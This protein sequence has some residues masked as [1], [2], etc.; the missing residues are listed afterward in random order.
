MICYQRD[1]HYHDEF[2][3]NYEKH[4]K[5][6][7][8]L[9]SQELQIIL[10]FNV[11]CFHDNN[12]STLKAIRRQIQPHVE[13][14]LFSSKCIFISIFQKNY[15]KI[16]KHLKETFFSKFSIPLFKTF[17][18]KNRTSKHQI[19]SQHLFSFQFTEIA[20]SFYCAKI[21]VRQQFNKFS[22]RLWVINIFC[23]TNCV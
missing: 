4:A 6:Q 16:Q 2:S 13:T 21:G 12:K 22:A 19:L 23:R 11:F 5:F 9:I 3:I 17:L 7:F 18:K 10:N 8:C 15:S 14:K 20:R 1:K